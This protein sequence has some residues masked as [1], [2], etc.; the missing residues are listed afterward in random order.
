MTML[1]VALDCTRRGW[2]VVPVKPPSEQ[3]DGKGAHLTSHGENSAS[4]DEA[5]IRLWWAKWPNANVA[6]AVD[7]S[8]LTV[9]DCD[10]LA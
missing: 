3:S 9:T 10:H 6:I 7:L 8:G 5:Q 1:E 2:H 4:N